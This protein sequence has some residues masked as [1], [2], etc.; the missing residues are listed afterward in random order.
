M[1]VAVEFFNVMYARPI[2]IDSVIGINA[3]IIAIGINFAQVEIQMASEE[4]NNLIAK[5]LLGTRLLG[6]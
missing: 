5:G 4:D 2:Q 6:K 1:E 3:E